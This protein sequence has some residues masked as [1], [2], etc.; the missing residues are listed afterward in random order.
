MS[1]GDAIELGGMLLAL[2]LAGFGCGY[3]VTIFR[4][5]MEQI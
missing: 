3:T 1:I 2:Y 4:K 5:F